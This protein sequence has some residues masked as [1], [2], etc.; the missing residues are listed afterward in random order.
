MALNCIWYPSLNKS[1]FRECD[2]GLQTFS[3][4]RLFHTLISQC[5]YLQNIVCF[6][7]RTLRLFFTTWHAV[8]KIALGALISI[9]C[10]PAKPRHFHIAFETSTL[11][12]ISSDPSKHLIHAPYIQWRSFFCQKSFTFLSAFSTFLGH[13]YLKPVGKND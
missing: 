2:T 3:E 9:I 1:R 4:I 11:I 13:L 8:S 7:T 10:H 5:V 6:I 12:W